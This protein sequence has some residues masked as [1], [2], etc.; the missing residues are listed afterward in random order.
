MQFP[1]DK[2]YKKG[3]NEKSQSNPC[4]SQYNKKYCLE[5]YYFKIKQ[6]GL[7]LLPPCHYI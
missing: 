5:R 7:L 3:I 4:M 2:F 6:I 1:Y